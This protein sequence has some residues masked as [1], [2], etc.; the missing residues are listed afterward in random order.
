MDDELFSHVE[1]YLTRPTHNFLNCFSCPHHFL[2]LMLIWHQTMCTRT[3]GNKRFPMSIRHGQVAWPLTSLFDCARLQAHVYQVSESFPRLRTAPE[4]L[5]LLFGYFPSI[6]RNCLIL[7]GLPPHFWRRL[8]F[9]C[10]FLSSFIHHLGFSRRLV[11][12]LLVQQVL[13]TLLLFLCGRR[14]SCIWTVRLSFCC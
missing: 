4:A 5:G 6:P 7:Y 12:G 13:F 9:P 10:D 2:V 8:F 11:S 3:I 1:L 14:C